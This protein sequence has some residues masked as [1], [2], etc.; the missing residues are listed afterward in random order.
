MRLTLAPLLS[1]LPGTAPLPERPNVISASDRPLPPPIITPETV[2][3]FLQTYR[4]TRIEAISR[5][6]LE[7][8]QYTPQGLVDLLK[9]EPLLNRLWGI[10]VVVRE[11]FSLEH[12]TRMVMERYEAHSD[13]PL[14]GGL[15]KGFMRFLSGNHDDGKPLAILLDAKEREH[16]FTVPMVA[17]LMRV[18]GFTQREINIATTLVRDSFGKSMALYRSGYRLIEAIEQGKEE[19]A[20]FNQHVLRDRL[21]N[22]PQ[23]AAILEEIESQR[24]MGQ[25]ALFAEDYALKTIVNSA[26]RTGLSPIEYFEL[27]VL[28]YSIDAGAYTTHANKGIPQVTQD[29]RS[30]FDDMFVV[31]ESGKYSFAPH[32]NIF[33]STVRE[34]LQQIKK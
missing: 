1:W 24:T 26:T 25:L 10:Q 15:T 11:E 3:S 2:L 16:D 7:G 17:N 9:P 13:E 34:K 21:G 14:P 6:Y 31:A 8:D 32:L 12:H 18:V 19:K 30:A 22:A 28:Y 4:P 23:A 27:S 20:M 29:N 33:A 5:D